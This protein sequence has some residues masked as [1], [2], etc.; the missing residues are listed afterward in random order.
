MENFL[1]H[2]HAKEYHWSGECFLSVKSFF[3]GQA[4]YHVG[5]REH[6]VDQNSFLLLNECTHYDL[7]IDTEEE[8]E[9]FCV[10]F[11]PDFVGNLLGERSSTDDQLLNLNIGDQRQ[12]RF[13]ERKYPNNGTVP[14]ILMQAKE[15]LTVH[16]SGIEVD[17]FYH[18][19]LGALIQL[20][21]KSREEADRLTLKRKT[22]REEIYQRVQHARDY[23]EGNYKL[24]LTLS[25]IASIAMLSENHLL[26]CFK[27]IMGITPFQYISRL[28][29]QEAKRQLLETDKP[30]TEIALHVGY[31]SMSNFSHYFKSIVGMAPSRVK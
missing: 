27:Q 6:H 20:N 10:F 2:Q 7:H 22:T 8:T 9:S 17:E 31:S 25:E 24:N 26:R 19:L 30:V 21:S 13:L 12:M 5:G 11:S 14:S 18:E 23:I 29:I 28:R 16:S 1:I 4:L 3:Q 15:R